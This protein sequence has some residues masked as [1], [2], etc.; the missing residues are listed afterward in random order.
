MIINVLHYCQWR[1]TPQPQVTM[2]G[3]FCELRTHGFSDM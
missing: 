2:F 3:K 1:T